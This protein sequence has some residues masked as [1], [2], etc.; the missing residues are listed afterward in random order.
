[1]ED[2]LILNSIRQICAEKPNLLPRIIDYATKGVQ[3]FAANQ[4]DK[5]SKMAFMMTQLLDEMP[6]KN[7]FGAFTRVEILESMTSLHGT[8]WHNKELKKWN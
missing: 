1:M 8:A 2:Q 7:K 6:D 4:N 3:D 5:T